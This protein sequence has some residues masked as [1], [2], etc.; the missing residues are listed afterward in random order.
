M[1]CL[2]PEYPVVQAAAASSRRG[3]LL[4][5]VG[6][7][8]PSGLSTTRPRSPS[9]FQS[10]MKQLAILRKGSPRSPRRR[11]RLQDDAPAVGNPEK[12]AFSQ[13]GFEP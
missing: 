10:V 12:G 7:S 1:V 2:A 9:P 3:Q 6:V 4:V 11:R 8:V 5:P 13:N